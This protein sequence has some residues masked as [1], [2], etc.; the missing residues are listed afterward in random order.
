MILGALTA[1]GFLIFLG[2]FFVV[3]LAL[4][5]LALVALLAALLRGPPRRL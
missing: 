2:L 4:G 1:V 5:V 3:L